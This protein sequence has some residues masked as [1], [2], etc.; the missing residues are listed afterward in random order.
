M[1]LFLVILVLFIGF[2]CK[3]KEAS[4]PNLPSDRI[5]EV[6][7]VS[8]D[9]LWQNLVFEKGGCLTGGQRVRDGEF[10][11]EGCVISS[12][13]R[14]KRADWR[15][16]FDH[17]KEELTEFLIGKFSD[18]SET[19]VHTCPF[20]S[21]TSGELAVYCLVKIHLINWFDFEPFLA[22]QDRQATD[23][24]DSEQTW[25]QGILAD[26]KQ[27]AILIEEWLKL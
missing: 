18:T 6:D 20:Y 19:K 8:L 2:S 22:Y 16:F 10:G 4:K 24:M 9:S 12:K 23:S 27:R 25:I 7:P 15:P 21:A 26:P 14:S 11:N 17:S 5:S 1:K 3:V 13:Y